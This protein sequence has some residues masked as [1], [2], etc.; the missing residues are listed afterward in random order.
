M[1]RLRIFTDEHIDKAVVEQLRQ[2]GIDVLRCEDAGMKSTDDSI[3]LEYATQ[4]GFVLLSMDRDVTRLAAQWATEGKHHGGIFYAP[5]AQFKGQAGIG[6][7]VRFCT[8]WSAR[9]ENQLDTL[10]DNIHNQLLYVTKR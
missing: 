5:M 6:S 2:R 4:N 3:L 8:A 1:S 10:S 7:I 9:I